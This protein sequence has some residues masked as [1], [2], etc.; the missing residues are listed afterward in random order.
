MRRTAVL[1]L[2]AGGPRDLARAQEQVSRSAGPSLRLTVPRTRPLDVAAA[3]EVLALGAATATRLV[4][5]YGAEGAWAARRAALGLAGRYGVSVRG[6]DVLLPLEPRA[7]KALQTA[8]VVVV[9]S[10]FLADAVLARRVKHARVVVVPPGVPLGPEPLPHDRPVPLA[11]FTGAFTEQSGVLDVAAVLREAPVDAHFVGSGPLLAALR[12]TGARV[13]VTDDPAVERVALDDAD[14]AVAAGTSTE[15]GDAEAWG[16]T[17]VQAQAAG[18]PVIAPR[19]GGLAQWVHPDGAVLV[20]SHGDLRRSLT[21]ALSALLA[22]REDW[23]AM[24]RAGREHVRRHLD[25]DTRTAE[26][27]GVWSARTTPAASGRGLRRPRRRSSERPA[28]AVAGADAV[29]LWPSVDHARP[30]VTSLTRTAN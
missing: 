27:E 23:P 25:V 12:A 5:C 22:R 21:D 8:A 7:T 18:I 15:D 26:L 14:L 10:Q 9:P 28:C 11:V 3:A 29:S 2:L 4:H 30:R 24:G 19:N 1:H 20:P 13:T 16:R 17:A 6:D